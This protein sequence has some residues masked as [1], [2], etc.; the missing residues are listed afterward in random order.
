MTNKTLESI[1]LNYRRGEE[2]V[3]CG[4]DCAMERLKK[5]EGRASDYRV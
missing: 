5:N 4:T 2:D 3:E 1:S